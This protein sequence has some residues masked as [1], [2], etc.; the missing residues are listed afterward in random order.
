MRE[1][2]YWQLYNESIKYQNHQIARDNENQF[3]L[4]Q[5]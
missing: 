5:V 1:L 4:S 2:W 3:F